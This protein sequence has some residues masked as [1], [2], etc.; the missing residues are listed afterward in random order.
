MAFD[1]DAYLAGGKSGGFDPD[2]YLAEGKPKT[3]PAVSATR[4]FVQG[5]TAGFSDELAGAISGAGR[6]AGIEGLGGP[7]KDISLSKDG[8]TSDWEILKE[9]YKRE[10]DKERESLKKDS[11][12]NP[13]T[14]AISEVAGAIVSPVNKIMPSASMAKSGAVIGGITGLG[15]SEAEDVGGIAKDVATGAVLGGTFGKVADK[16]AP[17]IEKG[18]ESAGRVVEK[19]KK[20]FGE[21]MMDIAETQAFKSS[22]AMLKDFRSASDRGMV[23]KVGRYMLDKGM[24]RAGDTV[25]DV[26]KKALADNMAAGQA[27]DDIYSKASEIFKDKMSG[28]GFDPVRDKSEIL[29]AAKEELGDT[30]GAEAAL[31]KLGK[32]LDEVASGHGDG[33]MHK[34]INKYRQEVAEYLP[35]QRQFLKDKKQFQ[36]QLG[37]A[38]DD[39][40]QGVLPGTFDDFQ[41]TGSETKTF[42]TPAN[43]M[44]AEV[45]KV[46]Q[47][48]GQMQLPVRPEAQVRPVK[49]QDIRNPMTPRRA[50][51][52]KGA[53]DNEINYSRNPLTKEPATEKAFHGARRKLLEKVEQGLDDLG[54]GELVDSLRKANKEY[55]YSKQVTQMAKDRVNRQTANKMFGLTDTI[56]AAGA[57]TYGMA[58]GDWE[59]AVLGIAGKKV[60]EKYGTS[61]IAA[62]ANRIGKQLL[63]NPEMRKLS[64]ESPKVF[65]ATV[66]SLIQKIEERGASVLPKAADKKDAPTKGPD[67]W[68]N[69]GMQKL[70]E[71][72]SS[73]SNDVLDQLLKT[74]KGKDLLIRASDLRPGSKAMQDLMTKIRSANSN[75][76]E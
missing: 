50:N 14:S 24:V 69:D 42:M 6:A 28:V 57:G 54:G 73:L 75:G 9:A 36:N 15:A 41:R 11:K 74:K 23:K 71:H 55:G 32:Y 20:A 21:K 12:D 67:K 17:H 4:K 44:D 61:I 68:A 37:S 19:A 64:V 31:N 40:D 76:G 2:A 39:L 35:K 8:P 63:K 51:D 26:G 13:A 1:P 34:A 47:G 38:A 16:A 33:P 10:R 18:L 22:G 66:Y 30:V 58:T 72:D 65:G 48:A 70:K 7:M 53:I 29:K 27:L 60:I 5:S 45:S 52:I 3:S 59:T 25:D 43:Y 49:P 56:T 46:S 62:A